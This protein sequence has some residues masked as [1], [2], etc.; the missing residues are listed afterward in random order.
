MRE[1]TEEEMHI[2]ARWTGEAAKEWWNRLDDAAR[3][4]IAQM[5]ADQIFVLGWLACR[6]KDAIKK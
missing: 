5:P 2:L 3:E 4:K 6:T 1:Y